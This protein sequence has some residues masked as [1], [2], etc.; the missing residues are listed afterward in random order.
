MK[1][2]YAFQKAPRCC[3]TSKRTKAPCKGVASVTAESETEG[4]LMHAERKP[5]ELH[6]VGSAFHNTKNRSV[7]NA[8]AP[9]SDSLLSQPASI[10]IVLPHV[11]GRG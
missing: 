9:S 6:R 2:K 8:K 4:A 5:G 1:R 7:I 10:Q 11:S 3:A